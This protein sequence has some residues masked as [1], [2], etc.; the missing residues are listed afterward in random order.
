MKF[1]HVML[2]L[3]GECL[4]HHKHGCLNKSKSNTPRFNILSCTFSIWLLLSFSSARLDFCF[5]CNFI[6][7][8]SHV[9]EFKKMERTRAISNMDFL[10][11]YNQYPCGLF[12]LAFKSLNQF[13]ELTIICMHTN[14]MVST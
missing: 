4:Q 11:K 6:N 5:L 10:F 7:H 9:V 3:Q 14:N 12:F 1:L 13:F 8:G 2:Q